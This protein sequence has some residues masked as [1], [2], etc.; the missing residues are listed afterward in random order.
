MGAITGH[1]TSG[2]KS[3]VNQFNPPPPEAGAHAGVFIVRAQQPYYNALKAPNHI[4]CW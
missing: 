4:S 1:A 2:M 3:L